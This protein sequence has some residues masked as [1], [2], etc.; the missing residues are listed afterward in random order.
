MLFQTKAKITIEFT[1]L[2][3][4]DDID[5]V[6]DTLNDRLIAALD[7]FRES[8]EDNNIAVCRAVAPYT[9]LQDATEF[10]VIDLDSPS[11]S[12]LDPELYGFDAEDSD[13]DDEDEDDD[14]SDQPETIAQDNEPSPT[15]KV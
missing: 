8:L 7:Y 15:K 11:K 12:S 1:L 10:V 4:E 5:S 9:Q 6:K 3:Q 13:D 2:S 14:D